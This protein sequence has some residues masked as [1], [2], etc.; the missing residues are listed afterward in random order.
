MQSARTPH[1]PLRPPPAYERN[2]DLVSVLIAVGCVLAT[3]MLYLAY[4]ML[5][6]GSPAGI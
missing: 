1:P 4:L 5:E 2:D 6:S 3:V